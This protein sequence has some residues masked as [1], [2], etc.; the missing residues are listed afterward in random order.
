ME[1]EKGF[2]KVKKVGGVGKDIPGKGIGMLKE[3]SCLLSCHLQ[4]K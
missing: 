1:E 3:V 2:R 4:E